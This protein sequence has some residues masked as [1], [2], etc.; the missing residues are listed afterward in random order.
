MATIDDK[1]AKDTNQFPPSHRRKIDGFRILSAEFLTAE[2]GGRYPLPEWEN[3]E[4]AKHICR[5]R[6]RQA[7]YLDR[8]TITDSSKPRLIPG[9]GVLISFAFARSAGVI[10]EVAF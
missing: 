7:R 8:Q 5:P 6:Q 4:R 1:G 3:I 9:S 10:G 2:R